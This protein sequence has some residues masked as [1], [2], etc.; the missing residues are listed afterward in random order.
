[1][2]ILE[3]GTTRYLTTDQPY[4]FLGTANQIHLDRK[5]VSVSN[6]SIEYILICTPQ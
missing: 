4:M 3:K 2:N 1:M 5:S 6:N